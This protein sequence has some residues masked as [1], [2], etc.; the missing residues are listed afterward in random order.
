M[1]QF[2]WLDPAPFFYSAGPKGCLL[3]HGFTGAPA[4]M[5]PMAE[6]LLNRNISVFGVR[7]AGHGTSPEDMARTTWQDWYASVEMAYDELRK[8]C[9]KVFV[10]GFSLGALLALHLSMSRDVAGL[11]L[12]SPAIGLRDKR[13]AYA[14]W[15]RHIVRV[16]E[17]DTDPRHADTTDPE[18]FMRFWSYDVN[19]TSSVWELLQLQEVVR[20]ELERVQCPTLV[21]C[22]TKDKDISPDAGRR[23]YDGVAASEKELMILHNSGHGIVVDSERLLVFQRAYEW[24]VAP[25]LVPPTP[26]QST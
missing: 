13:A 24:I 7:L 12:I 22:S 1:P 21:V 14:R 4:E 5:R 3:V 8:A 16:V 18:A 11:I 10:C 23:V 26:S 9:D 20:S 2:P 17:K 25:D 6:Y 15:L 19:P